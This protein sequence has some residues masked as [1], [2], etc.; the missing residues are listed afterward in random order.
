MGR[1]CTATL[2][3]LMYMLVATS[4]VEIDNVRSDSRVYF[5]AGEGVFKQQ[6]TLS[7]TCNHDDFGVV[8]KTKTITN[9]STGETRSLWIQCGTP[10]MH[11]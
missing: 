5:D 6:N 11:V 3:A 4:A 9:S 8:D 2:V 1:V 10:H 7:L